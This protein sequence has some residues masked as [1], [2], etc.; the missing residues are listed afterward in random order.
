ML[1]KERPPSRTEV[2]KRKGVIKHKASVLQFCSGITDLIPKYH[3]REHSLGSGVVYIKVSLVKSKGGVERASCS[4]L[5]PHRS[6][7]GCAGKRD[8]CGYVLLKAHARTLPGAFWPPDYF[9]FWSV[10]ATGQRSSSEIAGGRRNLLRLAFLCVVAGR[11][12]QGFYQYPF[13]IFSLRVCR[14]SRRPIAKKPGAVPCSQQKPVVVQLCL[15]RSLIY[16]DR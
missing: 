13:T 2:F 7:Q 15:C 10:Q 3:P 5:Q 4:I 16:Q 1:W 8:A 9:F 11:C 14:C 6:P 12:L